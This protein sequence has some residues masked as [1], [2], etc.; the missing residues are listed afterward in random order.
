MK[1][2]ATIPTIS[3]LFSRLSASGKI[4]RPNFPVIGWINSV[5]FAFKLR[6]GDQVIDGNVKI[7]GEA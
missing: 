2:R 5:F 3:L 1:N 4:K 6:A 7:G